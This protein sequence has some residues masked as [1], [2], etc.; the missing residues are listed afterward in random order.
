MNDDWSDLATMWQADAAGVSL[1]DIDAYLRREK[2][3]MAGVAAAE[4]AGL[5]AGLGAAALLLLLTP[6]FWLGVVIVV[7]GGVSAWISLRLR[8]ARPS[9]GV[10]DLLQSLKDSLDR[11][12]WIAEQLRLGRVLSFVALFALVMV[13]AVQ[14]LR[15][16]TFSATGLVS[17]GIGAAL[18]LCALAWNLWL[19][20]RARRRRERL[21]YLEQRLKA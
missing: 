15:L 2:R 8:R 19:T 9:P 5:A 4:I 18:V 1:E 7:F 11:E 10:R 6:H 3:H 16:K 21:H 17:A 12:D 20:A 14:L 13:T